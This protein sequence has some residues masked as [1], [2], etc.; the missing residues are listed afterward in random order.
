VQ[1]VN[2]SNGYKQ[3]MIFVIVTDNEM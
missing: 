1:T 3:S 2:V